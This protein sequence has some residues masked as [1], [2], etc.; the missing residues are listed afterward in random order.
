MAVDSWSCV[1]RLNR[2]YNLGDS[3]F[4][5][6]YLR[7]N[8]YAG[9]QHSYANQEVINYKIPIGG[10][11]GLANRPVRAPHKRRAIE[12]YA[13]AIIEFMS[14]KTLRSTGERLI[15]L[16]SRV[17]IV[18]APTSMTPSNPEFDD[19]N[20]KTCQIVCDETGFRLCREGMRSNFPPHPRVAQLV[21]SIYSGSQ[22][23]AEAQVD[24]EASIDIEA[25]VDA[26]SLRLGSAGC[27]GN[28]AWHGGA[29]QS[30]GVIRPEG[31]VRGRRRSN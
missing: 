12:N 27:S 19:R 15:D 1:D 9:F 31:A 4:C 28:A 16:G 22:G 8:P 13:G 14:S 30:A 20:V 29:G 5:F 2:P 10:E 24:V 25:T 23:D 17:G 6:Y 7:Y 3:D 11:S 21:W 18:P 26:H